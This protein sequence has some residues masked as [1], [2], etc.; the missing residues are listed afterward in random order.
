MTL[1]LD[2]EQERDRQSGSW[3]RAC[4]QPALIERVSWDRWLVLL[5]DSDDVHLVT[6][7]RENGRYHGACQIPH[8]D[9]E[10]E[11][12]P[13]FAHHDGPCAHLCALRRAAVVNQLDTKEQPVRIFDR[14]AVGTSR[15]DAHVEKSLVEGGRR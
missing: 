7:Y 11:D 13:G 6:L 1:P 5:A 14:E 12:C 9:Q 15:A 10:T 3:Q 2:F 8:D 4:D